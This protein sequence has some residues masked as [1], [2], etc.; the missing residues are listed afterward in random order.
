M[1]K[2]IVGLI[3][4]GFWVKNAPF[5]RAFITAA[6]DRILKHIQGEL[7]ES[8]KLGMR[9]TTASTYGRPGYAGG[10]KTDA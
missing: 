9:Y 3:L 4:G 7:P 8:S 5:R 2:F 1:K 6:S 10:K